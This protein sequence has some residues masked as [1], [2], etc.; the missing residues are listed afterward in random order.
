MDDEQEGSGTT[1]STTNDYEDEEQ[2]GTTGST[3]NAGQ[4]SGTTG[5]FAGPGT[6]TE[7]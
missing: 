3:A 5:G 7:G 1:G 2:N 6:S 4:G